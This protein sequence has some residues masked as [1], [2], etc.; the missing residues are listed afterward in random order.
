MR[1]LQ[2]RRTAAVLIGLILLAG[3]AIAT[4]A[5]DARAGAPPEWVEPVPAVGGGLAY[6]MGRGVR[7]ADRARRHPAVEIS[8]MSFN[9]CGGVC[10]RGEVTRTAR[11]VA[12]TAVARNASV[13]LLQELCYGQFLGVRSLLAAKGYTAS[14]ATTTQSAQCAIA[15]PGHRRGFGVAVLVRGPAHGRVV[16]PLPT[17]PGTEKRLLLGV[18]AV[19][20][21]RS[22]FV[23]VV[24]LSPS[25]AAGL[26][27]QLAVLARYLNPKASRPVI[28]GGDFNSLPGNPGLAGLYSAA[29]GGTGRFLETD[30]M[31]TGVAERGGAATFDTAGRK[32]DYVFLSDGWFGHPS[33]ASLPTTMSDHHVYIGTARI[34]GG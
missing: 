28:V 6:Q 9:V 34:A 15:D 4:R 1:S 12:R 10:H 14:F 19:V 31:R 32:I 24:H 16:K 23:A 18:T 25:P 21:G 22:T 8:V 3:L 29:A 17:P 5:T 33:A 2:T 7:S 30:E 27:G 13:L 11:Y 20:G 26:Q